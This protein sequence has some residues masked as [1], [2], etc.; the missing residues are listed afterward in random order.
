MQSK[1]E[2]GQKFGK[3]TTIKYINKHKKW[4]CKC[5][6][7][8]ITYV[9]TAQLNNGHTKSC[10]CLKKA[11][12]GIKTNSNLTKDPLYKKWL[13]YKKTNPDNVE[14]NESF[15]TFKKWYNHKNKYKITKN[16]RNQWNS[17]IKNN[18]TG[19]FN[20]LESYCEWA[21][22]QGYIDEIFTL[23]R[24][25]KKRPH[26]KRNTIFGFWYN[27]IFITS[28][29]FKKYHFK[30]VENKKVYYGYIKYNNVTTTTKRYLF[31]K[32]MLSEYCQIYK[33]LYK[34]DFKLT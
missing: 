3:L 27:G 1:I 5:D 22:K 17:C 18:Q 23:S 13:Y 10:G 16:L 24:K 30:Y 12:V 28:K 34:K 7:G 11:Q 9:G 8:R 29:D 31:F 14:I 25:N 2:I 6:C 15:T 4:K 20:S 32:D 19:I 33:F 26:S 21:Y